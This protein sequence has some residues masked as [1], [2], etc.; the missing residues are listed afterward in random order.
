[1]NEI[2]LFI[3]FLKE[4]CVQRWNMDKIVFQG[5]ESFRIRINYSLIITEESKIR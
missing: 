4:F 2:Y 5:D 1:M 3:I